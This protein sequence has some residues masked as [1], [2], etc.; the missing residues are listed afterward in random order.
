VQTAITTDLDGSELGLAEEVREVNEAVLGVGFSPA[1]G[2]ERRHLDDWAHAP[3]MA[4]LSRYGAHALPPKS[5]NL[6]WLLL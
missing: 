4:A 3:F 2:L 5:D 6:R 1:A